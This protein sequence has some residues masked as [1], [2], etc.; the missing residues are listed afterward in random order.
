MSSSTCIVFDEKRCVNCKACEIHCRQ[1]HGISLP[2][3]RQLGGTPALKEGKVSLPMGFVTCVHCAR[4]ACLRAC[5]HDAMWLDE[6]NIVHIDADRCTG[7]DACVTACP[8][9]VPH[10]DAV[11]GKAC[12][13]DLCHDR[14]KAGLEPVCVAG[15]L[16]RALHVSND[17]DM[18]RKMSR[19]TIRWIK[20]LAGSLPE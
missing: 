2:L 16:A 3:C 17:E 18:H 12:K 7:C 8:Y 20:D 19:Q 5:T 9:H 10:L 13:C 14:R 4:P 15:C 11:T 6:E 1:W